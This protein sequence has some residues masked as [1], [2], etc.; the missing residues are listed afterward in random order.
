MII[1]DFQVE[2]KV[3]RPSFFQGIFFV[4][5]TKFEVIL[6]MPFLKFSNANMLFGKGTIT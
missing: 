2:N 1:A 6:R 3:G 5:N 4:A